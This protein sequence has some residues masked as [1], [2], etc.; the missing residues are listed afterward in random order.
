VK[1]VACALLI[2]SIAL[3][4]PFV[5]VARGEEYTSNFSG[6]WTMYDN[7]NI[8]QL[9]LVQ[10]G[11]RIRGEVSFAVANRTDSVFGSVSPGIADW[12][13]KKI[14]FRRRGVE[15]EYTGYMMTHAEYAYRAMA[16]VF[17]TTYP[18]DGYA[19]WYATR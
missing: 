19:G 9:T 4:F 16:G 12:G 7:G 18:E 2:G 11:N 10:D 1:R 3:G 6:D 14:T 8:G 17:H 5:G 13:I 15:H